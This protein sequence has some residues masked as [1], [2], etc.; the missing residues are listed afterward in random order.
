[1][2]KYEGQ[3]FT[4]GEHQSDTLIVSGMYHSVNLEVKL[5]TSGHKEISFVLWSWLNN[6]DR[7]SLLRIK[8]FTGI[9]KE[10]RHINFRVTSNKSHFSDL[11]SPHSVA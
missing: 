3:N 1:M 5:D 2:V 4:L 11:S 7:I 9:F 8:D 6:S 10:R